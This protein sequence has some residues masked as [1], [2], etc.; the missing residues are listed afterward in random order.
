MPG[1]LTRHYFKNYKTAIMFSCNLFVF[2]EHADFKTKSGI[3]A[4]G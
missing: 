3:A 2:G 4:F 1:Q